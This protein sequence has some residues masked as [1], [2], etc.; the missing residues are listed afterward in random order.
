MNQP[1]IKVIL[2]V[3]V[4]LSRPYDPDVCVD[5]SSQKITLPQY[6]DKVSGLELRGLGLRVRGL[7]SNFQFVALL[8]SI[9]AHQ[10]CLALEG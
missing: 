8:R 3:Q 6:F 10:I 5:Y 9:S 7:R 2:G 1:N 4:L